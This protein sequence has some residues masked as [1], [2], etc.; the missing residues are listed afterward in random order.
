MFYGLG[1]PPVPQLNLFIQ[2]AAGTCKAITLSLCTDAG[3]CSCGLER[4]WEFVL[5]LFVKE[6]FLNYETIRIASV[7]KT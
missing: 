4:I 7:N 5:T 6:C 1:V 2:T 3:V